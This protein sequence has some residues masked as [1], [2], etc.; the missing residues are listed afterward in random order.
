MN[1]KDH[2]IS[3]EVRALAKGFLLVLCQAKQAI[4]ASICLEGIEDAPTSE[5]FTARG[6]LGD[7][8]S[9]RLQGTRVAV[10]CVRRQRGP[11]LAPTHKV[12]SPS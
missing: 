1:D 10:K 2:P 11:L 6:G 8:K 4:P 9:A 3:P 12:F 5:A 7:V